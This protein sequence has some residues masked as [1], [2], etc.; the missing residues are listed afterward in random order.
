[1][2]ENYRLL[3]P[4]FRGLPIIIL[5]MVA[6]VLLAS[7]ELKYITPKY[8][9]T[10]KLKFADIREGTSGGNLFKDFDVFA[11]A[12]KIDAEIEVMKSGVL[13]NK[14]LDSLDFD[15]EIYRVGKIRKV[16][17]YNQSP[18]VIKASFRNAKVFDN[19]FKLKVLSDKDFELKYPEDLKTIKG[20]FGQIINNEFGELYIGLN[21]GYLSG[22]QDAQLIDQY[23]F[24]VYSREKLLAKVKDNLDIQPVD[25]DVPVVRIT[26]KSPNARKSADLV[27]KIGK[28]YIYDYIESKYK[29]ANTTV[30]FLGNQ[31]NDVSTKLS[32][33]ENEIQGYR[34]L[35][36]ITNINQ[37]T[38]TDLRAVSQMKIQL[39]NEK[40][41]LQA[42]TE[43][44]NYIQA[45]KDNFLELAPNFE[46]FT[47]LLSTEIIKNIKKLQADKKDLLISYTPDEEKVKVIDQKIN[48]LK[49]YLIE[50]ITNT[51]KNHEAKIDKLSNEITEAEKAFIGIPEKEKEL[52]IMN[53]DFQLYQTSYNF[54]N[55]KKIEAE[56]AQAA[57]I[58]FHRIIEEATPPKDPVSPNRPIILIVS[59]ILG[60]IGSIILIYTVHAAKAKV[61]DSYTIE[62]KSTIP[63]AAELPLFTSKVQINTLFHKMALQLELKNLLQAKTVVTLSSYA[64]GEGK[65]FI[66]KELAMELHR[67]GR[68]VLVLDVDHTINDK[69]WAGN[70]TITV[71][72][73]SKDS[74]EGLNTEYLTKFID[75]WKTDFDI[76]IIKNEGLKDSPNSLL[77]INAAD[78]NLFIMDSRI[79][80]AKMIDEVEIMKDEYKLQNIFFLLNRA[81]YNPEIIRQFWSLLKNRIQESGK[82]R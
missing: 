25:K 68:K 73:F 41:T 35:K 6:A 27:N 5:V 45:G 49:A 24:E 10:T 18:I 71:K 55:E 44:C 53:R 43:L 65:R 2:N 40:M 31:I 39:T 15:V 62:K 17:L 79:T 50:S 29:A 67:Q 30:A 34:D 42:M 12:N 64:T 77:F 69:E 74:L 22:K 59:A 7:K 20:K 8:E 70:H 80:P 36:N 51:K 26:Y 38:E 78:V 14:V 9:A 11:S 57:R 52:N 75:T 13:L 48:D 54:L 16:E 60:M 56:I 23:E 82:N 61:N 1:M 3:K 19:R 28:T 33:S 81:G 66:T 21:E 76:I 47:D 37:E 4:F 46:A 32:K 58:S 63:I 72:H